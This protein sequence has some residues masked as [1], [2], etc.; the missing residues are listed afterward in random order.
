MKTKREKREEKLLK[1]WK[2]RQEKAGHDVSNVKT[3]EEARHFFDSPGDKTASPKKTAGEGKT[4]AP[5]NKKADK[6]KSGAV[7]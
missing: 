2:A 7:K 4:S 5:K 3:L 6:K 1:S